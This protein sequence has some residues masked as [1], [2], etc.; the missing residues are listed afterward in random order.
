MEVWIVLHGD[1]WV[2]ADW[3]TEWNIYGFYDSEAKAS[4]MKQKLESDEEAYWKSLSDYERK[5]YEIT[6]YRMEKHSVQ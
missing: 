1:S 2:D 3:H 5:E 4:E 6:E